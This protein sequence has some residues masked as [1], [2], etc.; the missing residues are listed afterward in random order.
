MY[1]KRSIKFLL[2]KRKADV[3]EN[4]AIRM[5]VTISGQTPIDIPTGHNVDL[6]AWDAENE[7]VL[8]GVTNKANQTTDD[9]NRTIDDYKAKI[10]EVFARYELLEK[11][12]PSTIEARDLFYD[13]VGKPNKN[14]KLPIPENN[15]GKIWDLFVSTAGLHNQWVDATY[16]KFNSLKA[17]FL[18]FKKDITLAEIND[19]FMYAFVNYMQSKKAMQ[20]SNKNA[21]KGMRN[22][23]IQ[24]NVQ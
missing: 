13:M 4:L 9:I 17:H 18:N 20:L 23:T 3:T 12:V 14:I 15:F 22:T 1:I 19:D 2:H 24:K 6:D 7:K 11:R 8:P 10:N 16:T 5:R 21:T